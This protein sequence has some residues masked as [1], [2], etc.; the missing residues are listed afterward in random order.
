VGSSLEGLCRELRKSGFAGACILEGGIGRW[1][2]AGKPI[3]GMA[4][5]TFRSDRVTADQMRMLASSTRW[6]IIL[7]DETLDTRSQVLVSTGEHIPFNDPKVFAERLKKQATATDEAMLIITRKGRKYGEIKAALNGLKVPVYYLEGGFNAYE[8]KLRMMV[9]M[10]ES[11]TATVSYSPSNKK[12]TGSFQ[13][14]R[15]IKKSCGCGG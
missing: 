7:A 8:A 13:G 1:A 10:E 5:D 6:E 9:D 15:R 14:G 2:S 11:Q 12:V 3:A 4:L